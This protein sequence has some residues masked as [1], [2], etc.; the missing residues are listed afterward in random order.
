MNTKT[1]RDI[2]LMRT[3]CLK[4]TLNF[5]RHFFVERFK[6]KFV[7]G[8]HH[9]KICAALDDVISGKTKKLIINIAPRY[10]KTELAV[11]NFIAMGLALNPKA[12]FIHLSY[13][14]DLVLDNSSE[15]QSIMNEPEYQRLFN[16]APTTSNS[17]KW[18]TSEGGGLY[19][20]SSSGQV[21]GFGAG[22]V[23]QAEKEEEKSID[24][25]TV[26]CIDEEQF[27]GAIIID[28]A[29]KPDDARS[30]VIRNKVNTKFDTTIRN[31]VNS[32]NTPIVIIGQRVDEE[33]LCGFLMN[34]EPGEWT[35]LSLP[36]IYEENGEE[37][38]LWPFKH[39]LD[40]LKALRD[41]N[42]F[43][44]DTQYMQE[45][46]PLQGLM[47]EQGFREY[48]N[49]PAGAKV[50]KSYTDT[51]DEGE[52]Y[53]CSIVYDEMAHA[54]YIIDVIYTQK[55]MEF[56]EPLTA[57]QFT[58]HKVATA[59]VESN[60][61]GRGF[62]RAVEKQCREMNNNHTR[63]KWFHQS[64]NKQVRIF[65]RSGEVQNLCFMPKGWEKMWPGF[66]KSLTSYMKVGKNKHDDAPDALTGTVEYRA[67]KA[68]N[69][70]QLA[71]MLP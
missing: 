59:L 52:D 61:G 33:D 46:K 60:N 34:Q 23:D 49:I 36:C 68:Q 19:A 40:E 5:T 10:G 69:L 45:P 7:V 16:V 55:P 12:K 6:R 29:I 71:S 38:A 26:S 37:K 70:A 39:T 53:L 22:L 57:E 32:R 14:D 43:V 4:S 20:V 64:E 24:E 21:T 1:V 35:V 30:P 3:W 65:T 50:R 63:I 2:D 48:E 67:K 62:A 31:R 11:K 13:S 8:D 51:A 47:Y 66:Y 56:T 17:K 25:F 28:D 54:N 9:K 27:G 42:S 41:I 58:K 15:I 18:Y 44:F